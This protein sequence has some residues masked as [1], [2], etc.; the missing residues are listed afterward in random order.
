M[1]WALEVSQRLLEQLLVRL[2]LLLLSVAWRLASRS[3]RLSA[4]YLAKPRPYAPKRLLWRVH[5]Y[6]VVLVRLSKT[7]SDDP[8]PP[9]K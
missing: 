3:V 4:K 5:L 1:L 8:L 7:N 9:L 2:L 6:Y